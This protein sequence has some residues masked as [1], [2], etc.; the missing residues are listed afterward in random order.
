MDATIWTFLSSLIIPSFILII[1]ILFKNAINQLIGRISHVEGLGLKMDAYKSTNSDLGKTL[2]SKVSVSQPFLNYPGISVLGYYYDWKHNFQLNWQHANWSSTQTLKEIEKG[3]K[4]EMME[5]GI[6][7]LNKAKEISE[8]PIILT[9]YNPYA[10]ISVL[11]GWN[12]YDIEDSIETIKEMHKKNMEP[13]G[14]KLKFKPPHTDKNTQGSYMEAIG[15]SKN[16]EHKNMPPFN[17]SQRI[18]SDSG[19][20]YVI[21]A[22]YPINLSQNIK[23]EIN[24][25][26]NSFKFITYNNTQFEDKNSINN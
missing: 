16:P 13:H 17:L 25:I 5:Q 18:A 15:T 22:I 6:N 14:I 9:R 3:E 19:K 20:Y 24:L 23:D 8:I 12:E 2:V 7:I 26:V 1:L 21:T 10:S 4:N 11:V